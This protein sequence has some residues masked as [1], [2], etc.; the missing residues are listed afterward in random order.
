MI[1]ILGSIAGSVLALSLMPPR[2]I[3][4]FVRRAV[5][6]LIFGFIFAAPLREWLEWLPTS[7]NTLASACAASF[8]SWWV[9]G[10][11]IRIIRNWNY[12]SK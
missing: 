7:E 2:S 12:P 1:R 11:I 5:T 10:S 8:V 9:M 4:G 3:A 6:S